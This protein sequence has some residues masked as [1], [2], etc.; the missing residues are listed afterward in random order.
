MSGMEGGS[1]LC[2]LGGR[3]SILA[4]ILECEMYFSTSNLLLVG[5]NL[6]PR[7]CR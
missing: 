3:V 2:S 1:E 4:L 6:N 5:V 7:L